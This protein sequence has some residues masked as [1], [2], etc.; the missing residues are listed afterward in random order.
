MLDMT[1]FEATK[2]AISYS[3][4]MHMYTENLQGEDSPFIRDK[5]ATSV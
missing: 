2:A 4:Y 5:T 3:S 1:L